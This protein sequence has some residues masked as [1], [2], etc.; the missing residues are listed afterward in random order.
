MHCTGVMCEAFTTTVEGSV[1]KNCTSGIS[2]VG[3]VGDTCIVMYYNITELWLCQNNREWTT[4][5]G[6]YSV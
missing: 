5:S 2:G 1:I 3:Y 4:V 6:K